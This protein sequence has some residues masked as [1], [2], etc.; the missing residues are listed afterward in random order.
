MAITAIVVGAAAVGAV[1]A[2]KS[3]NAQ[4]K[5]SEKSQRQQELSYSRS[6]REA[7]R[8]AQIRRAQLIS[9]T[10][11][12]GAGSSSGLSGGL[13]SLG[14]QLGSTLGYASQMSGLAKEQAMYQSQ[15]A[16]LGAYS[17][18]AFGVSSLAS[19]FMPAPKPRQPKPTQS[20]PGSTRF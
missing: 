1:T 20:A 5:A 2:V 14:S 6:Q 11:G 7:F 16:T 8:E 9:S 13:G 3:A 19:Q 12:M 10:Q 15:A 18:L 17:N 4:K